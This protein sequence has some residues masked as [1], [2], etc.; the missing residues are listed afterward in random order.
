M[1]DFRS[2]KIIGMATSLALTMSAQPGLSAPEDT[3]LWP[4]MTGGPEEPGLRPYPLGEEPESLG[5]DDGSVTPG[6]DDF[7]YESSDEDDRFLTPRTTDLVVSDMLVGSET[8]SLYDRYKRVDCLRDEL[9]RIA[10]GM[11]RTGDYAEMRQALEQAA[12]KLDTIVRANIDQTVPARRYRAPTTKGPR[13]SRTPI[14]AIAP[15]NLN[16]ANA[17]A[18]AVLDE[19]STTLLR[20]A[21]SSTRKQVHFE[22][23]AQAVDSM[24][25]LLRS[26]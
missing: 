12:A 2:L 3:V 5:T 1:T 25:V 9:Q 10:Q 18:A 11:P 7:D 19:L 21:S 13:V 14:R 4:P 16:R 22:R 15:R 20:S 17:Q 26:A 23:A 6:P 8:C 24:K